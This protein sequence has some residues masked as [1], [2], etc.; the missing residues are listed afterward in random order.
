MTFDEIIS[1]FFKIRTVEYY[2]TISSTNDR[3]KEMFREPESPELPCL[4]IARHQTAGRGRGNKSWWSGDGALL[5]SLGFELS[6]LFLQRNH[7]SLFSLASGLAAV[8]T[9]RNRVPKTFEVGLH[10]SNDIYADN[11]KIGGILIESPT[12]QHLVLGIGINVNNRLTEI[13]AEFQLE[14][15]QHPIT[16]LIEILDQPIFL[17]AL[18]VEFLFRLHRAAERITVEPAELVRDAE[19]CCLQIGKEVTIR[20]E[21]ATILGRCVGIAP[22]GSLRLETQNGLE[23]VRCGVVDAGN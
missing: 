13:P 1:M 22:D 8:E 20:Q 16:S 21:N 14:L 3:V 19:T 12:P 9:I 7:L 15:K 17:P 11:K 6:S 23:L 2:D 4:V 10:W 5:L 18:I